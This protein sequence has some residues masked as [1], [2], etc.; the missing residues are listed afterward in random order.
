MSGPALRRVA[1]LTRRHLMGTYRRLPVAFDRGKGV[2]LWDLEGREYLDFLGGIAVSSLGH[3]DADL[4][5]AL[6]EQVGRLLHVSNLYHV[7][8][9]AEA[10]RLLTEISGL[11]QAFFCNSGAEAVEAAIKLSRK[12][13]RA[14]KGEDAREIVVAQGAFHGRTLGA[15]AATANPSYREPFEPLPDGFRRVPYDDLAAAREA[16]GPRTCAVL[17]EP[18]Q[19][20][21][22]VVPG[23][24][25]VLAGLEAAAREH[26]ALF[27][28][29]EVQTGVGRTGAPFAF[30]RYGLEPDAVALAK[31]LGGGVPVGALL[32]RREA[33]ETLVPGDHA[34]T[35][36][37]NPLAS[38]AV[39]TVLQALRDRGLCENAE[40]VGRHLRDRLEALGRAGLP[41]ER[42]RGLGL[43]VG[44]DVPGIARRVA[45]A[46]LEDGLLVNAIGNATLRLAPP[47][48]VTRE[49]A[50]RA[51]EILRGALPRAAS[52]PAARTT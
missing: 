30:Q 43:L 9:Q 37:G 51:V 2:R 36:G 33:A 39:C 40:T 41:V 31:G 15:L 52:A 46:C 26:G 29:D 20:E 24:P 32:A 10:A 8:E 50:D 28:L 38:R 19:G 48:V 25:D 14:T 42:V 34:S 23:D 4:V 12:W 17:V 11:D 18:V 7:P 45:D 5:D 3:A 35:F 27:V 16:V 6:R 44:V 49:D 22:G 13:G 21:S 1:R 47:L